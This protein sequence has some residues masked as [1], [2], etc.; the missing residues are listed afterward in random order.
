MV[1]LRK[2]ERDHENRSENFAEEHVQPSKPN[3]TNFGSL[4]AEGD[5]YAAVSVR[6]AIVGFRH[7]MLNFSRVFP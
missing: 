6:R 1:L 4:V 5:A 2:S 7:G 3:N